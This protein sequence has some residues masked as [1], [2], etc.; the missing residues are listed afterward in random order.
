[1]NI[2]V[3][4]KGLMNKQFG[5]VAFY[6]NGFGDV[7]IIDHALYIKGTRIPIKRS[8]VPAAFREFVI[9]RHSNRPYHELTFH[10]EPNG[11]YKKSSKS[12]SNVGDRVLG[13]LLGFGMS[14]YL[15]PPCDPED[16]NF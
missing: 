1:M 8:L 12:Y 9:I 2:K 3:T 13:K 15:Y 6:N 10:I 7:N 4:V 11:C 14:E 16:P 5:D